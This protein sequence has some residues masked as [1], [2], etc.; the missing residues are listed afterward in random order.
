V[1][2][3]CQLRAAAILAGQAPPF[4]P[5]L[6]PLASIPREVSLLRG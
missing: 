5:A 1:V 4:L 3:R 6:P 2:E